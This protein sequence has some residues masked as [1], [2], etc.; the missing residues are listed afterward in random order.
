M[1]VR[2]SLNVD[3]D[4]TQDN[5]DFLSRK[6]IRPINLYDCT[7]AEVAHAAQ[8]EIIALLSGLVSRCVAT[9]VEVE[10]V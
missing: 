2:V 5:W 1:A 6:Y 8:Q 10:E 9:P 4:I 7:D 3:V